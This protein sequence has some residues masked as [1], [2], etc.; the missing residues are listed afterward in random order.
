[1]A[2]Q[3]WRRAST[4]RDEFDAEAAAYDT[5]RPRYPENLF[6]AV[7]DAVGGAGATAVEIGAG[8]GLATEPLVR[9][10]LRVTAIEPAPAMAAIAKEKLDGRFELVVTT[11][12]EWDP[13][14]PVDLVAAFTS[15]HWIEPAVGVP[16]V[17][18][19]LRPGGVLALVWTE[20]IQF[21]E[22][23]FD[24]LSG[25]DT[26]RVAL[27]ELE[28]VLR[29]VDVH[30]AFGPRVVSRFR[31]ERVLDADTFTAEHRTYPGPH[32]E[33]N[34]EKVRTLITGRFGGTVTKVERRGAPHV[35]TRYEGQA[36][37]VRPPPAGSE[38]RCRPSTRPSGWRTRPERTSARAAT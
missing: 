8:T 28:P 19:L 34:D 14:A 27:S 12:E 25:Y 24:E 26:R 2:E 32:S 18:S 7:L 23:P 11:F 1:M 5:F 13:R 37:T 33:A 31:F 20:V 38:R 3:P 29:P 15:W 9:R 30:G 22:P 16:K 17:A 35:P 4:R 36:R 21:G 6:D 10:G